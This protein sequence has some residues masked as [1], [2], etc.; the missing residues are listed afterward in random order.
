M[1]NL[2]VDMLEFNSGEEKLPAMSVSFNTFIMH[3]IINKDRMMERRKQQLTES[4]RSVQVNPQMI[5]VAL[6]FGCV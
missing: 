3:N 4:I 5:C 6:M 1:I 2:D